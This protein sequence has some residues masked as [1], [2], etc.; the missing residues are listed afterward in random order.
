MDQVIFGVV[1]ACLACGVSS[2][3][4]N[5]SS[6]TEINNAVS[7][8]LHNKEV[9]KYFDVIKYG[10]AIPKYNYYRKMCFQEYLYPD[11]MECSAYVVSQCYPDRSKIYNRTV[12]KAWTEISDICND[13]DLKTDCIG[14]AIRSDLTNCEKR[15]MALQDQSISPLCRQLKAYAVC[16]V[17]E[18]RKC[19]EYTAKYWGGHLQNFN[20]RFCKADPH[21]PSS[22]TQ[23]GSTTLTLILLVSF[24]VWQKS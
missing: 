20:N 11:A 8:C 2:Y 13:V 21:K 3:D 24:A 5:C 7:I 10:V 6:T 14:N 12:V 23:V 22:T 15:Q 18:M 1:L 16:V 9:L 19:D 4:A 17:G